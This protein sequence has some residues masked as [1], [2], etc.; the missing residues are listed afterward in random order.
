ML[1]ASSS[2]LDVHQ[3]NDHH[4]SLTKQLKLWLKHKIGISNNS[5]K[6]SVVEIV[7][8]H[9]NTN[10][11]EISTEE[12][13]ML[14]NVLN[15]RDTKVSD[16][17]IPRTDIIA[18]EKSISLAEL[19]ATLIR[20]E[21]TRMPVYRD[22]L[23]HVVGFVHI[24]D[25]IPFLANKKDF[26]ID[27]IIRELLIISPTMKNSDLL[28]KMRLSRVHMAL[29][30]DEYGGTDGL[31]TFE[32]LVEEIFGDIKDEHDYALEPEYIRLDANTIE[33]NARMSIDK[34]ES[35]L[36]I[37]IADDESD[38]GT[39]GGLLLSMVGYVPVKGEKIEHSSGI[40]FEILDSD[41]RRLKKIII[42]KHDEV[43]A[44]NH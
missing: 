43:V 23:D 37:H 33:A 22:S 41:P 39:L 13:K 26:N 9:N 16:I 44:L 21:H 40:K 15:F 35:L 3:K 29:I 11:T 20:E 5:F 12:K 4:V 42:Y 8:E 31:V 32:D 28:A 24:K 18:V 14:K 38:F 1:R 30:L 10:N 34:L 27:S 2:D 36:N 17:M 19:T 25:V 7:E 6:E